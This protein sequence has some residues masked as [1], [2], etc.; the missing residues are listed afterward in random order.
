MLRLS[1]FERQTD[2]PGCTPVLGSPGHVQAG[3]SGKPC[4]LRK[5]LMPLRYALSG[6]EQRKWAPYPGLCAG[7][8]SREACAKPDHEAVINEKAPDAV[9]PGLTSGLAW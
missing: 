2:S 5:M 9:H 6:P 8:L 7:C 1:F 4:N 3:R